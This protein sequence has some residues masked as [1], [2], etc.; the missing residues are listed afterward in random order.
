M[1]SPKD[2]ILADP[3]PINSR[4]RIEFRDQVY[5]GRR[6]IHFRRWYLDEESGEYQP[7]PKGVC[8]R[9][10]DLPAFKERL[11]DVLAAINERLDEDGE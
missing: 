6:Y 3:L 4:E 2:K 10:E 8:V 9:E 1:T 7:S 5:Q 11:E